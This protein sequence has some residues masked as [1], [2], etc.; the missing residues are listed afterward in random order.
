MSTGADNPRSELKEMGYF[1]DDCD[2]RLLPGQQ[3]F[4]LVLFLLSK[5]STIYGCETVF[6]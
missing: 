5:S 1:I 3:G 4:I 6:L 2:H